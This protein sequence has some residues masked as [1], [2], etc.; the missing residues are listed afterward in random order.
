MT[1][2]LLVYGGVLVVSNVDVNA[3]AL[4]SGESVIVFR[5]PRRLPRPTLTRWSCFSEEL[6][7]PLSSPLIPL[8]VH[9]GLRCKSVCSWVRC[10]DVKER[11]ND[12]CW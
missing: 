8:L 4:L 9:E 1:A 12:C 11:A 5:L 7:W 10:I 2:T 3:R 6:M